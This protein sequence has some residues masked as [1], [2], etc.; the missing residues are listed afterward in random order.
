MAPPQHESTPAAPHAA[1]TAPL[2]RAAQRELHARLLAGDTNATSELAHAFLPW[3]SERLARRFRR[4]DPHLLDSIAID[5]VL[6]L[7]EQPARYDPARGSLDHYLLMDAEGDVR[8]ALNSQARRAA[9]MVSLETVELRTAA[10]NIQQGADE[11]EDE[12]LASLVAEVAGS[13]PRERAVLE[14]MLD[15]ERRTRP[16]VEVLGLHGLPPDEQRREVKRWKD[17]LKKRLRRLRRELLHDE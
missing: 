5:C 2:D 3:L 10:G 11:P 9:R 17:R 6:R 15:G 1:S 14:L 16:Y 13:D 7:C 12:N 8:N 4:A